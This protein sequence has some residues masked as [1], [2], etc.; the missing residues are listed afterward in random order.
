MPKCSSKALVAERARR[1]WGRLTWTQLKQLG[2]SDA[3]VADWLRQGYLHRLL[4]RVY[5]VGHPASGYEADLAAALLYSGPGAMLSHDTA[6]HWLGLLDDR[7]RQIHVSTPRQRSSQPGIAVHPRRGGARIWHNGFPTTTVAETL[8]DLARERPLRTVRRALANADYR[9]V[10]DLAAVA[11]T[12]RPGRPGGAR[13][14]AA[15]A[16]HQPALARTK[17]ANESRF[18]E[19]CERAGITVPEINVHVAG[20]EVDAFFRAERIAVELD[21]YGNHRSPAQVRRDRRKEMA[22]RRAGCTPV[23]YSDE[24][25]HRYGQEVIA[26]VLALL[27]AARRAD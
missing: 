11:R 12:L 3:T 25:L 23:R 22:L 1:Q 10:L 19:L 16:E 6:A 26:D 24:Q 20:W 9:G 7:P 27:A 14:R 5:A 21:G 18:L 8:L 13:L 15:L 17:S 4:P 2:L